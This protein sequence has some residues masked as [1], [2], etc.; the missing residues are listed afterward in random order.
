MSAVSALEDEGDRFPQ[1]RQALFPRFAL[2]VRSRDLG[3]VRDVPLAVLLDDGCELVA[4]VI[5]LPLA[6]RENSY[7]WVLTCLRLEG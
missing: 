1:V 3:A 5:I 4:H 2:A 7:I 6:T